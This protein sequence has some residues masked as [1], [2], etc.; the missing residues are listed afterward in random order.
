MIGYGCSMQAALLFMCASFHC[1]REK[2]SR[3]RCQSS[4]T[5][6]HMHWGCW[7]FGNV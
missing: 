6:S 2:G 5:T 7:A 1:L 4:A 3:R